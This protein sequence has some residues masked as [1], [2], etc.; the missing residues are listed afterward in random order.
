MTEGKEIVCVFKGSVI[1]VN[2]YMER[3]DEINVPSFIKNDFQTGIH[4]GFIGGS[5]EAIELLVNIDDVEKA[6]DCIEGL[7]G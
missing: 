6:L 5:P 7:G 1:D 2:Y 4:A 3:L